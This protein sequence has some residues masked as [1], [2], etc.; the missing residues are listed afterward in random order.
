MR[1]VWLTRHGPPEVLELRDAVV[2]EPSRDKVLIKVAVAGINL[3]ES[4]RA[5]GSSPTRSLAAS[6]DTRW[7]AKLP[8]LDI[9]QW[10]LPWETR[11]WR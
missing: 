9:P 1:Q 11:S 10:G 4:W 2:P 6:S 3:A 8:R 7:R 5:S